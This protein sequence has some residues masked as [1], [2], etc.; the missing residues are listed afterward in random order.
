MQKNKIIFGRTGTLR[1]INILNNDFLG[2]H[3][4]LWRRYNDYI[5]KN[6]DNNT[7]S[8]EAIS[9]TILTLTGLAACVLNDVFIKL[10]MYNSQR[11]IDGRDHLEYLQ[12]QLDTARTETEG[13][14][15]QVAHLRAREP[16]INPRTP[17]LRDVG[18]IQQR[19]RSA[20][21]DH[22]VDHTTE[23]DD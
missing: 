21:D 18:S 19:E 9:G 7:I 1:I 10:A 13:L 11:V 6:Q 16:S 8:A 15:E 14:R 5:N 17:L 23:M 20:G 22:F 3:P 12:R 2:F 4:K